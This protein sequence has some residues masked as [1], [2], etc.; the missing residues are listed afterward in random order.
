MPASMMSDANGSSP[1]VIGSSIAIAG[2]GPIPGNT[3]IRVPRRQPSN[4]NPILVRDAAAPNPVARLPMTSKTKP[5]EEPT[6]PTASVSEQRKWLAQ[7]PDERH[8]TKEGHADGE[9]RSI[10]EVWPSL[11][12]G[13]DRDE[14]ESREDQPEVLHRKSE[15]EERADD[16]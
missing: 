12:K 13:R 3:P 2:I 10:S 4:A 14:R 11:G 6:S 7:G 15:C 1:K 9:Q 16:Q 8:D 5:D